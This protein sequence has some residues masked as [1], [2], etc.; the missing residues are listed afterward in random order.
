[1]LSGGNKLVK[2][3]EEQLGNAFRQFGELSVAY[4]QYTRLGV[5][6]MHHSSAKA[7]SLRSEVNSFRENNPEGLVKL[8]EDKL[9]SM[10]EAV[11]PPEITEP[12]IRKEI[13][14][15]RAYLARIK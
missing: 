11:N 14:L 15:G 6:G 13:N 9:K 3:S 2:Y 7:Q 10:E 8:V 5:S 4:D 12:R 1:M